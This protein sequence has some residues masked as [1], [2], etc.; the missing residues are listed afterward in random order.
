MV[1]D[2]LNWKQ[3][4]FSSI[5]F[6][7][8]KELI[9]NSSLSPLWLLFEDTFLHTFQQLVTR[10]RNLLCRNCNKNEN[11]TETS[12][13]VEGLIVQLYIYTCV[14]AKGKRPAKPI[15]QGSLVDWHCHFFRHKS[16]KSIKST[17]QPA[18][19]PGVFLISVQPCNSVNFICSRQICNKLAKLRKH[20]SRVSFGSKK[21]GPN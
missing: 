1:I 11:L 19:H 7:S 3:M 20:A 5:R 4:F 13:V 12:H 14:P 15:A 10:K 16:I 8:C 18:R 9:V 17:N 2:I 21:F 6:N